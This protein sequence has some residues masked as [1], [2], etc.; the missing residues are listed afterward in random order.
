MEKRLS[1]G[2]FKN[3]LKEELR[4][5]GGGRDKEGEGKVVHEGALSRVMPKGREHMGGL[6]CW[7]G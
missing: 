6:S 7:W 3:R 1:S 2:M 5:S 4:E